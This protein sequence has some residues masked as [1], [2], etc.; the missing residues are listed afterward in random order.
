MPTPTDPIQLD[1]FPEEYDPVQVQRVMEATVRRL[2]DEA[3][4]PE[5]TPTV[6]SVSEEEP[7]TALADN[8]IHWVL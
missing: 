6:T 7:F 1:Q 4:T 8:I 5:P 3:E 2:T